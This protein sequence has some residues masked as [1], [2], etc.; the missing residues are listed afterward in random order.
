MIGVFENLRLYR[1]IVDG[2]GYGLASEGGKWSD[3]LDYAQDAILM[4]SLASKVDR[5]DLVDCFVAASRATFLQQMH[6]AGL[7]Q[8]AM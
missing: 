2:D 8:D 6:A 5:S 7:M 4:G 1:A 3:S